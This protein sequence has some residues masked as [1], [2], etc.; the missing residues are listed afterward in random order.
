MMFFD[1][2]CLED[3]TLDNAA[4]LTGLTIEEARRE[5]EWLRSAT[6][7]RLGRGQGS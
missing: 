2:Y 1:A 7:E 5:W 6:A 3:R 4:F